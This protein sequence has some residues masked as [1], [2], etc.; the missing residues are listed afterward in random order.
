MK[1]VIRGGTVVS[2]SGSFSA[3]VLIDGEKIIAIGNKQT[4]NALIDD[5]TQ[6]IDA[7]GKLLFP[8]FIDAHT[9]LDLHVAGTV[10]ADNFDTGTKAA[11][12]GGTTTIIDFGTQY[13]GETLAQGLANWHKKA[14]NNCSC[15][16]SFHMSIS[17]WNKHISKEIQDIMDEGITSFKLY[18]TYDIMVNDKTIY[19]ILQRL[20]EVGG[21][22]GVHCE[23]DGIIAAL[24]EQALKSS[25]KDVSN[26]YK[27][28]PDDA[29]A[30]A[31]NRLLAIA[32]VVDIPVIV[33]HL[34]CKKAYDV[35]MQA[36]AHGQ[37]VYAETCPQ[38]LL[39]DSTKYNL[40]YDEA[41]K[42][43]CA[44][45][46]RTKMDQECLWQALTKEDIQTVST[47]HCS[48]TTKQKDL[49]KNDFT[50]IPGGVPGIEN[51]GLLIYSFGV[52]D[53]RI[54]KETMCKVLSENPAKLYGLYPR[55]GII[56][57]GS[58]ADIVILDPNASQ[59]ITAKN[60]AQNVDYTPYEGMHIFGKIDL[61]LLRGHAVVKCNKLLQEKIGKFIKRKKYNL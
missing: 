43:V 59:T 33:V 13:Q 50:K 39:L 24:K 28:R 54:S 21:I 9:H 29:E 15:D 57:P 52:H 56:A 11:I 18:M 10:T 16:Y 47:D 60:L 25:P 58:D 42:F 40:S 30:E 46:L 55:K 31:V 34:T 53:R 23:N 22:T 7:S 20:K 17:E 6:I 51:R 48:F 4:I 32:N 2:G 14:D 37:K 3:D 35:I 1:K 45:P 61:V 19:E 38:Y 8:G 27:T 49:G 5:T 26:H 36:R 41:K 12:K 44:P